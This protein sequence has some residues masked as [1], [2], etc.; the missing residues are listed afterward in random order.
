MTMTRLVPKI[1]FNHMAEGLDLFVDCLG[2]EVQYQDAELAVVARDGAKAY[3][4]ESPEYAAKD[5]PEIAIETDSIRELHAEISSK[6]PEMLHP[7]SKVVTRKPWGA[8]EFA[9]LDKT[10]VCVIFRQW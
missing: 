6:R 2:F 7:N 4:V 10:H 9:V 3:I 5:R 8:Q 1:F